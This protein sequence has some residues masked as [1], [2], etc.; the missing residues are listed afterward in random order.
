MV[1]AKMINE[2]VFNED[3]DISVIRKGIEML[4]SESVVFTHFVAEGDTFVTLIN[5]KTEESLEFVFP[6]NSVVGSRLCLIEDRNDLGKE[7]YGGLKDV[8]ANRA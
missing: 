6:T 2:V 1:K 4:E 8:I 5:T 3:S 7:I